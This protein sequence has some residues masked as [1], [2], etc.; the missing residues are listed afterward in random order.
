MFKC[1]S[2]VF[3]SFIDFFLQ[4]YV[5]GVNGEYVNCGWVNGGLYKQG[6]AHKGELNYEPKGS[7]GS[8]ESWGVGQTSSHV[9]QN[10][11]PGIFSLKSVYKHFPCTRI[12][13]IC[14]GWCQIL[15]V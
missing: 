3:V 13:M 1:D 15:E 9:I 10:I 5:S 7:R 8:E 12:A 11:A 6:R 4:R 2:A 14:S